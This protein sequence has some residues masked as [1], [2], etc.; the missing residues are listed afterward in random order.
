MFLAD[1]GE[2]I[3][4]TTDAETAKKVA[5]KAHEVNKEA[6]L[7]ALE[8]WFSLV[9]R[10]GLSTITPEDIEKRINAG[11]LREEGGAR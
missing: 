6:K 10:S 9:K 1:T 8:E 7:K 3:I 4:I 11:I 2:V 5:E